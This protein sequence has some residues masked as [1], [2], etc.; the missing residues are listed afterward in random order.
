MCDCGM[1]WKD[2]YRGVSW[3]ENSLDTFQQVSI[4][5]EIEMKILAKMFKFENKCVPFETHCEIARL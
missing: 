5:F 4:K 3:K 2:G 1:Q